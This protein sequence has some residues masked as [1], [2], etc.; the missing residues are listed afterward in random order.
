[1]K[2]FR[3]FLCLSMLLVGASVN[4]PVFS[5]YSKPLIS[6][7]EWEQM[8]QITGLNKPYPKEWTTQETPTS[9]PERSI[10]P[11]FTPEEWEQMNQITGVNVP[12]PKEWTTQSTAAPASG[13]GR[14]FKELVHAGRM[15]ITPE[16]WAEAEEKWNAKAASS[17][18][19][20][21]KLPFETV[22]EMD[23]ITGLNQSGLFPYV[24]PERKPGPAGKKS[25][26]NTTVAT[27]VP[28]T[29]IAQQ[30]RSNSY[31]KTGKNKE[32]KQI[33]SGFFRSL[34]TETVFNDIAT[35]G[36][37]RIGESM[38]LV[39]ALGKAERGEPLTPAEESIIK[40]HNLGR[41]VDEYI[42]KR[43]GLTA[44]AAIGEGIAESIPY[45]K[46]MFVRSRWMFVGL[47]GEAWFYII[48]SI[49]GTAVCVAIALRRQARHRKTL[50]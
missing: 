32:E 17:S 12:Y 42:R 45:M 36:T 29:S 48:F 19:D 37:N 22:A 10:K 1:M 11:S 15:S 46:T 6:P 35:V 3:C 30:Q 7:E 26:S 43:G 24:L 14:R 4:A 41:D 5:A 38:L 28:A 13:P 20:L 9:V 25:A 39:R 18:E 34:F 47:G 21:Y 44:G 31:S 27:N 33:S 23:R 2:Y 49:A 50:Q 8:N 16:Q 40:I